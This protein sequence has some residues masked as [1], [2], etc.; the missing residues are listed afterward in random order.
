MAARRY[1]GP[2][3]VT[4]VVKTNGARP[5]A[6]SEPMTSYGSIDSPPEET[7]LAR[8]L[9]LQAEPFSNF[10]LGE[11]HWLLPLMK[12]SFA[13]SPISEDEEQLCE[14][15]HHPVIT[16]KGQLEWLAS[17]QEL[18][19]LLGTETT[20]RFWDFF[21]LY[22]LIFAFIMFAN[23]FITVLIV[24]FTSTTSSDAATAATVNLCVAILVR[25]EHVVNTMFRIACALKP[26]APLS[27][28]RIGGKVY[29][30]GGFHS[31]CAMAGM[32]WY[33]AFTILLGTDLQDPYKRP[34]FGFA[35]FTSTLL[36]IISWTAFPTFRVSYHNTFEA[37]HR[38]A[39]WFSVTLLW[40][41]LGAS[42]ATSNY[43]SGEPVGLLLAQ[44]PLF[45]CLCIITLAIIYPWSRLR[46]RDVHVQVLSPRAAL[47]HFDYRRMDTCQGIRITNSP[48]KETHSF[49]TISRV[50]EEQGFRVLMSRAGDWTSEF[51][52]NP[53]TSIWVKGAPIYGV[54]RVALIFKKVLVVA[55]GTGIGPCL[56][57]LESCPE[58]DMHVLWMGSKPRESYGDGIINSVFTA[59][60]GACIVDTSKAG[61]GD[62]LRLVHARYVESESEAIVIISNASVTRQVVGGLESR[63]IPAFGAIFDS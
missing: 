25:N 28:R 14:K 23:F 54:M 18:P 46:L 26:S 61:R 1:S 12:S 60:S 36:L 49:A 44:S 8:A 10:G 47:L 15:A 19:A 42:V 59:D 33:L 32:L 31:G 6:N 27:I 13:S 30:Y 48:L 4:V 16:D 2:P 5:R 3:A 39:G 43:F 11:K 40:A 21:S 37:V 9:R 51:I 22:R 35:V 38:F 34:A 53:P 29:S 7:R 56:S 58:F 24:P 41:Q 52:D 62:I 57:L 63:G 45:W 20:R 55:T 50:G 17:S